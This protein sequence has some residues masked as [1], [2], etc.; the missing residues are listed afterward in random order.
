MIARVHVY[1]WMHMW[2]QCW[3]SFCQSSDDRC[4]WVLSGSSA[5]YSSEHEATLKD[6][7]A[8]S[9]LRCDWLEN[10]VCETLKKKKQSHAEI[11]RL[12]TP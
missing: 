10:D 4:P 2:M 9:T 12:T 11:D 7:E 5:K 3:P 1:I 8:H 6:T